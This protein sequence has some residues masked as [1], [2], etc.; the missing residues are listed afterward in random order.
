MDVR[1]WQVTAD[2]VFPNHLPVGIDAEGKPQWPQQLI[3]Q[4][5]IPAAHRQMDGAD[6]FVYEG[7]KESIPQIRDDLRFALGQVAIRLESGADDPTSAI[8]EA[9][10]F[11]DRV[12][13]SLSFQT[14]TALQ[15]HSVRAIDLTGEPAVGDERACGEWSGFATPTFRA[16]SVPMQS[17]V[18]RIVPDVNFDLDPN[19]A[20]ANRALDWYLKALTAPFEADDFIFLWI[21]CEILAAD[22]DIKVSEPYRGP[23]C[24][25]V[26]GECPQCRAPTTKPVQGASMKRWLTEGFSVDEEVAKRLWKARQ[27]LH[28]AHAFDSTIMDDLP[29]LSQWLRA[30]VVAEVKRR[31][32]VPDDEPPFAAPKGLTVSP[33][34]GL[35][36]TAKVSESDLN[37]LG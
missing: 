37:P 33:S 7:D 2:V 5:R 14:Q 11:I 28:G 20:Q 15:I 22:S 13:E 12:L 21:A 34:M 24:G 31:L 3:P 23:A 30:V 25:H 19:D 16:T 10:P 35:E 29:E 1:T 17:L 6:V 26:I 36:G 27:V 8:Q 32:G 18:G 4:S 9:A